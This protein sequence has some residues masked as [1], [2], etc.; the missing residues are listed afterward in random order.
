MTTPN[1]APLFLDDQPVPLTDAKPQLHAILDAAGK[2]EATQVQWL[3]SP[4][5]TKG[6]MLRAE[7]VVDR[8]AQPT[9]PIYLTSAGGAHPAGGAASPAG[10]A[11]ATQSRA[12]PD[13]ARRM[14]DLQ[15]EGRAVDLQT[16]SESPKKGAADEAGR[17]V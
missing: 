9:K 5:A 10:D 13:E 11:D 17:A 1:L 8:T 12:G 7:E 4:S 15:T 2:P 14:P 3:S 16:E 6:R